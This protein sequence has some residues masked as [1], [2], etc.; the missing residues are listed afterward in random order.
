MITAIHALPK[1][2]RPIPRRQGS[3]IS[4]KKDLDANAIA[5][6][7]RRSHDEITKLWPVMFM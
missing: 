4:R 6:S 3:H 1:M 2:L 5:A 7:G